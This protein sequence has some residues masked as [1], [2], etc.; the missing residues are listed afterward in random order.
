MEYSIY[1]CLTG[2]L[3]WPP[4]K[5]TLDS[6]RTLSWYVSYRRLSS[7][8]Q[9]S[10]SLV[11]LEYLSQW[12]SHCFIP[13]PIPP[14]RPPVWDIHIKPSTTQRF[15]KKLQNS[16]VTDRLL[17]S[18]R[19]WRLSQAIDPYLCLL[20]KTYRYYAYRVP[21]QKQNPQA[22]DISPEPLR[23]IQKIMSF[24]IYSIIVHW[25]VHRLRKG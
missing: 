22:I 4:Q 18:S 16:M 11:T 17:D 9:F 7:Q 5:A 24:P 1:L 3:L 6:L 10:L 15:P 21:K 8:F 19:N 20:K 14:P 12:Y 25:T 2:E 23:D 13:C